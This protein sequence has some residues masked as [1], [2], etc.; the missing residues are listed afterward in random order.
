MEHLISSQSALVRAIFRKLL[1]IPLQQG[2][3]LAVSLEL[4]DLLFKT[5]DGLN[6]LGVWLTHAFR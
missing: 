3:K 5:E 1:D 6:A 4:R 2:E